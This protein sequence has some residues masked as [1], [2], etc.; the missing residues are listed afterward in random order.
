[1]R[2]AAE[3]P[4]DMT[5]PEPTASEASGVAEGPADASPHGSVEHD[6]SL[7]K[8][9]IVDPVAEDTLAKMATARAYL[10]TLFGGDQPAGVAEVL[11]EEASLQGSM[12]EGDTVLNM[13]Q[14]QHQLLKRKQ[15]DHAAEVAAAQAAS[16]AKDAQFRKDIDEVARCQSDL[17]LAPAKV[18]TQQGGSSG[19]HQ[20]A[21]AADQ[22]PWKDWHRGSASSVASNG[23]RAPSADPKPHLAATPKAPPMAHL[24]YKA[25]AKPGAKLSK[26]QSQKTGQSPAAQ[27]WHKVKNHVSHQKNWDLNAMYRIWTRQASRSQVDARH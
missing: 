24:G 1:L 5:P 17:S 13:Q 7:V 25:T 20:L 14:R 23:S 18:K 19:S 2:A 4:L 3:A 16:E 22:N 6:A 26:S 8:A 12:A 10:A 9:E 15:N 11:L 21:T 27:L